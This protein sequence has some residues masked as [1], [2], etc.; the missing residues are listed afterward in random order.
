MLTCLAAGIASFFFT[1]LKAGPAVVVVD[2]A[3]AVQV[4]EKERVAIDPPNPPPQPPP[5]PPPPPPKPAVV[6]LQAP[7]VDLSVSAAASRVK[8]I[9]FAEGAQGVGYLHW[10]DAGNQTRFDYW[11]WKTGQRLATIPVAG[12]TIGMN[13]SPEGTRV[14]VQKS[15]PPALSAWTLPDGQEILHEWNP[16]LG[17][18]KLPG[19]PDVPELVWAYLL[20]EDR[21]LTVCR[22]GQFDVWSLARRQLLASNPPPARSVFLQGSG[23]ARAPRNFALSPNRKVLAIKNESGFDLFEAATARRLGQTEPLAPELRTGNV[24]S[25]GFNREGTKLASR[26]T[27]RLPGGK[28]HDAILVWNVPGGERESLLPISDPIDTRGPLC[29]LGPRHLMLYDGNVFKGVIFRLTDGRGVR[30]C[31]DPSPSNHF[32]RLGPDDRIW[33]QSGRAVNAP[34]QILAVDLPEQLLRDEPL[35]ADGPNMMP[36]WYFSPQGITL[37]RP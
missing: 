22:S 18:P 34:A 12:S 36:R 19:E 30:L 2:K 31:E 4:A 33:Y 24:W 23:F 27:L 11:N 10:T 1:G 13:L 28:S 15:F 25:V 5:L 26:Q 20:D 9:V 29:W 35:P 7:G 6:V 17:I 21:V 8:D 14:I 37:E 32:A 3:V 16:Y